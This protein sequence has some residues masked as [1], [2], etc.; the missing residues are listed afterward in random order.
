MGL[1]Q[2]PIAFYRMFNPFTPN[3]T[4]SLIPSTVTPVQ[5]GKSRLWYKTNNLQRLP[6]RENKRVRESV[7]GQFTE[8]VSESVV[9]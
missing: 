8:S 5:E 2:K 1:S 4:G 7:M 9:E 3:F 6:F